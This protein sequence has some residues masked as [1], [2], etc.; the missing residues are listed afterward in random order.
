MTTAARPRIRLE[1]LPRRLRLARPELIALA[2]LAGVLDLWALGRN[3]WANEYYSAA[4]RTM[5]SDW[6][7]FLFG[8]LDPAGLQTVDKPP[9]ALWVQALSVRVFGFSGEAILVPQALM[10]VAS[11]LLVY[12]LTRRV[13]GR[14]AGTVAGAALALTPVAVAMS[15]HNNPEALLILASAGALWCTVRA[16]QDGRLRWVLGAGACVGLAFEAKMAA[17]LLVVPGIA[18][19]WM[20]VAPGGH[21]VAARRLLAGAGAMVAVGGAWPLVVALTPAADRPWISGTS[22]NS[23]WSLITGYNGLGRIAGQAGGPQ[24]GGFGAG[25]V[26]GGDP[27]VWRLFNA[28][29]GPQGGWLVGAAA[30]AAI[31]VAA[32][33]RLRRGD[34]RTGWVIAVGGAF[35]VTAVAFSVAGGIF[36]PYYVALLAPY[37]AALTGAGVAALR[38]A[39]L[40][41]RVLAPAMVM[42]GVVAELAVIRNGAGDL[43]WL[44]TP[45]VLGGVAAATLLAVALT[46]RVRTWALAGI[47]AL[48]LLGPAVWSFQTLGH[49]TNG[50]FPAGG[51]QASA[52]GGPPGGGVGGPP[53]GGGFGGGA[54]SGGG[55]FGGGTSELSSALGYVDANGGGTLVV[56]SQST[57]ASAILDGDDVAGIGGFSGRE[58][59]VTTAWLSQAVASG[60]VR[61]VLASTSQGG[62][63]LGGDD[64]TG[65]EAAMSAVSASCT[66][67][68]VD[69][70]YDCSGAA[71]ALAEAA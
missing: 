37:T 32:A 61:W 68:A 18:A 12:D 15:R 19:A 60:R 26:F 55:M 40:P 42:A 63:R 51:P 11:V 38:G 24:G 1:A 17:G 10:G 28:S 35:A 46:P 70:L 30:V 69:G 53:G 45:L 47:V 23:V 33:C 3:G 2:A 44:R 9:A 50:T 25:G 13:F 39:D 27:G 71:A 34:A 49:A 43:G 16:L 59:E 65:G 67:T 48:L 56:S 41:A 54:P 22:D 58:S 20:W 8:A 29:L 64:R 4:V 36:H 31:A 5:A 62:P 52:V 14:I 66:A 7:A 6:H 57:A 21:A